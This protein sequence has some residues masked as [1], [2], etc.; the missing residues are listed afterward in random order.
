M[1]RDYTYQEIELDDLEEDGDIFLCPVDGC[2]GWMKD[3]EVIEQKGESIFLEFSCTHCYHKL[4]IGHERPTDI[5][6]AVPEE[7]I[8]VH[9]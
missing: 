2:D 6:L 4:Y 8:N 5:S 9:A 1:S 7:D 3:Y